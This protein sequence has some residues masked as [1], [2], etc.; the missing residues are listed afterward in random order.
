MV[1]TLH[2]PVPRIRH[3]MLPRPMHHTLLNQQNLIRDT[4]A[5]LCDSTLRRAMIINISIC[6]DT[7]LLQQRRRRQWDIILTL[8]LLVVVHSSPIVD[9]LF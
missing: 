9:D 2:P 8:E 4:H 3:P 7:L 5:M 6:S 1:H